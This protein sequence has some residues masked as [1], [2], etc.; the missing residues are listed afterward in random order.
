MADH[1][2]SK[3]GEIAEIHTKVDKIEHVIDG[4]GK[5]GLRDTVVILSEQVT[6]LIR[7]IEDMEKKRQ[8]NLTTVIS[9]AAIIISTVVAILKI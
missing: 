9:L 1:K 6:T 4:N 2:C 7:V 8:F 3:E 5:P